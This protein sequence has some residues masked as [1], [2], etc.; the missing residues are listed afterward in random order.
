MSVCLSVCLA[1]WLTDVYEHEQSLHTLFIPLSFSLSASQ[2]SSLGGVQV[3]VLDLEEDSERTAVQ[4][5]LLRVSGIGRSLF[6]YSPESENF[7]ASARRQAEMF[8]HRPPKKIPCSQGDVR[9]EVN[10]AHS[11]GILQP[12]PRIVRV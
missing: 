7:E 12:G 5:S 11:H 4:L 3:P 8:S 2:L 10:L 6:V 9:V 1:A